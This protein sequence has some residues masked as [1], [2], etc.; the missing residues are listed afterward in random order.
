M[1]SLA[2]DWESS[3]VAQAPVRTDFHKSLNIKGNGFTQIPFNHAIS[4]NDTPDT[5]GFVFSQVFNLGMDVYD[6]FLADLGRS[7]FSNTV[8]VGQTNLDPFVQRQ[9]HSCDSSQFLPPP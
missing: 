3:P 8:N 4:L 9:I 2:S 7:A 6:C 1:R 5:H